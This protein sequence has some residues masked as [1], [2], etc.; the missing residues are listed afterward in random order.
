MLSAWIFRLPPLHPPGS[1]KLPR[2]FPQ[3]LHGPARRVVQYSDPAFFYCQRP[4]NA[5]T[6]ALLFPLP[7]LT[8]GGKAGKIKRLERQGAL[9]YWLFRDPAAAADCKVPGLF[10]FSGA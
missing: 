10:Q 2:C 4:L 7:L 8:A 1:F 6:I 9:P 5:I 3:L